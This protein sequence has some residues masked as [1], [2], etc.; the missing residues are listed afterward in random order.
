MKNTRKSSALYR[1]NVHWD[2]RREVHYP[3]TAFFYHNTNW[4]KGMKKKLIKCCIW[5]WKLMM[6]LKFIKAVK[7]PLSMCLE[8]SIPYGDVS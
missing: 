8:K 1:E 2:F 7:L 5:E 6:G 3:V 4:E